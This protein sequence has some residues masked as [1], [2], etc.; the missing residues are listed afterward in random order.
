M[1]P[2]TIVIYTKNTEK[3]YYIDVYHKGE[4]RFFFFPP[5]KCNNILLEYFIP[6]FSWQLK[7]KNNVDVY[8][9]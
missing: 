1:S 8:L 3:I 5:Q 6:Y 9:P 2:F 4:K 7:A